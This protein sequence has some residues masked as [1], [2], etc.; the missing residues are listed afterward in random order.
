MR[1]KPT[2]VFDDVERVDP[3]PARQLE[4]T[5][6]FLNRVRSSFFEIVRQLIERWARA[7]PDVPRRDAIA[8][9][10]SGK[11]YNWDA[12]IWELYIHAC[13]VESGFEVRPHPSE[14]TER[15]DPDFLARRG[16]NEFL[17]EARIVYADGISADALARRGTIIDL[18]NRIQA[19]HAFLSVSFRRDA[20]Y[21][22]P[23][24]G[25]RRDL[26]AWLASIDFGA[27]DPACALTY[28]WRHGDWD[29]LFRAGPRE[30]PDRDD[31]L[32]GIQTLGFWGSDT[33]QAVS[34]VLEEKAS[35]Y[36]DT[37][38]PMVLAV[39]AP[40]I[41]FDQ[42]D[43]RDG[44][45]RFFGRTVARRVCAVV[46]AL[47]WSPF[48]L[49]TNR[50]AVSRHEGADRRLPASLPWESAGLIDMLGLPAEWAAFRAA[51]FER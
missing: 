50:P 43:L 26:E 47:H 30:P 16:T 21:S 11:R 28:R 14:W 45:A 51:P 44:I 6:A 17:L 1:K 8:R 13:L 2:T 29:V 41:E 35:K 34:T 32:V 5:H 23:T 24:R 22:P 15:G 4:S 40:G 49:D 48:T 25:L 18:V 38:V 37:L 7:L 12:A 3:S 10:R 39:N 27:T 20:P 33:A 42:D 31:R 9:L 46:S 19:P 36:G